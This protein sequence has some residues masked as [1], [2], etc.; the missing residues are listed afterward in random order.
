MT[1]IY[2][3]LLELMSANPRRVLVERVS[4]STFSKVRIA[5]RA[6]RSR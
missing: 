5:W 6:A 1:Q 2:H 3:G 4:L